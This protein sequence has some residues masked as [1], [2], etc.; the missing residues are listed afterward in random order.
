MQNFEE[1]R[2]ISE[3]ETKRIPIINIHVMADEEWNRIAYRN[4]LE[5]RCANE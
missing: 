1:V 5:R 3:Q 2:N 4:Y